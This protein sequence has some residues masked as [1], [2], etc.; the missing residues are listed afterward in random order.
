MRTGR[1]IL[2]SLTFVFFISIAFGYIFALKYEP[3]TKNM[4]ENLFSEFGFVGSLKHYEV[5][6]FI[7]LNNTLKAFS[8]MILGVFLGIVPLLFVV[9]NGIVIGVV[10][11]YVGMEIGILRTLLLLIPHGILEIPAILV[12]CAY[13]FEMGIAFYRL[14]R[15]ERISLDAVI[16]EH[17]KKFVKIP[18]PMLLVAALIETY[19]TPVVGGL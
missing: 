12:S 15:G 18:L 19:I 17:L 5:F 13:G 9:F 2:I 6:A 11:G 1:T 8:A 10:V 16:L 14:L 3:L 7:F 4:V